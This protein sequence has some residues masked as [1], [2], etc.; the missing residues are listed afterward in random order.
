MAKKGK[1]KKKGPGQAAAA[2]AVARS[3]GQGQQGP[4]TRHWRPRNRSGDQDIS[5]ALPQLLPR[6]Q[7]NYDSV[8]AAHGAV[9]SL[10]R[11]RIGIG[12]TPY[13]EGTGYK[14]FIA[15]MLTWARSR[16]CDFKQEETL[17]SLQAIVARSV[18]SRGSVYARYRLEESNRLRGLNMLQ[19][20][21]IEDTD[22]DKSK[23][24]PGFRDDDGQ[25]IEGKVYDGRGRWT[26]LW[27][28]RRPP[29]TD[30]GTQTSML[31][32]ADELVHIYEKPRPNTATGV[33]DGSRSLVA[34]RDLD[35]CR[36][37]EL[38]KQ[39]IAACHVG[40]RTVSE[41]IPLGDD[42]AT[43]TDD[44]TR[45]T[46]GAFYKL[47]PGETVGFNNPPESPDYHNFTKTQYSAIAV[48]YCVPTPHVSGDYDKVNYTNYRA[49]RIET[50]TEA[51]MWQHHVMIKFLNFVA[52]KYLMVEGMLN[53][54]RTT[55]RRLPAEILWRFPPP[56]M[57][58]PH[59]EI[60]A[61]V[62]SVR[63][64]FDTLEGVQ[65][66]NNFNPEDVVASAQRTNRR[67]DDAG[68]VFITDGRVPDKG[69]AVPVDPADDE[70]DSG[71]SS[72]VSTNQQPLAV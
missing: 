70:A 5:Q 7:D 4:R 69:G 49:N 27:V 62:T 29:G 50:L 25:T 37:N 20:Q 32:S 46:A 34:I 35:A 21:I 16:F 44:P 24:T 45:I 14:K 47:N 11:N 58:E 56:M 41:D 71:V 30:G 6:A 9:R 31:I 42:D 23:D 13:V 28:Y 26:G 40:Y 12:A 2:A 66:E 65:I 3:Y 48:D 17:F 33:P 63:A 8:P 1:R 15:G 38:K 18:S 19:I 68:V 51:K 72:T 67:A 43:E 22:V 36:M 53:I 52:E 64:G 10:V 39:E 57:L 61:K 60:P 55:R 59:R 54:V